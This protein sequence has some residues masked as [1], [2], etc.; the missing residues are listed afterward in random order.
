MRG[1]LREFEVREEVEEFD[2]RLYKFLAIIRLDSH[3]L[4]SYLLSPPLLEA[5]H[6]S[7]LIKNRKFRDNLK[8]VILKLLD[9]EGF[10]RDTEGRYKALLEEISTLLDMLPQQEDSIFSNYIPINRELLLGETLKD[11]YDQIKKILGR[12]DIICGAS[13]IRKNF[14]NYCFF[15]ALVK[16]RNEFSHTAK[17]RPKVREAIKVLDSTYEKIEKQNYLIMPRDL[18]LINIYHVTADNEYSYYIYDLT[19][20]SQP[21]VQRKNIRSRVRLSPNILYVA[22]LTKDFYEILYYINPFVLHYSNKTFFLTGYKKNKSLFFSPIY[23][24]RISFDQNNSIFYFV[25][26]FFERLERIYSYLENQITLEGWEK[27]VKDYWN[28][29][30]DSEISYLQY[31]LPQKDSDKKSIYKLF[32]VLD[33]LS[34]EDL[35]LF[36]NKRLSII[37]ELHRY[38]KY[39]IEK[40]RWRKVINILEISET[41]KNDILNSLKNGDKVKLALLTRE[42]EIED[43]N[44]LCDMIGLTPNIKILK[45]KGVVEFQCDQIPANFILKDAWINDNYEILLTGTRGESIIKCDFLKHR[46]YDIKFHNIFGE[47]RIIGVSRNLSCILIFDKNKD[48]IIFDYKRLDVKW[49]KQL[50]NI[51]SFFDISPDCKSVLFQSLDSISLVQLE[52]NG[53]KFTLPI[54][55]KNLKKATFSADTKGL[56]LATRLKQNGNELSYYSITSRGF[57]KAERASEVYLNTDLEK[58]LGDDTCSVAMTDRDEVIILKK[59]RM[60]E[61]TYQI[62]NILLNNIGDIKDIDFMGNLIVIASK[63]YI[64]IYD[65]DTLNLLHKFEF[66]SDISRLKLSPSGDFLLVIL[67]TISG[68]INKVKIFKLI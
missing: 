39:L 7:G 56:F 24:E 14:K 13:K 15:S 38:V 57:E 62:L 19:T 55:P 34:V 16:L 11:D 63:N 43:K 41:I 42:N 6:S 25:A 3:L 50:G 22:R 35:K 61:D 30:I 27:F 20:D 2:Y 54:R 36:H 33:G 53:R 48:L 17:Y 64:Y 52:E 44:I 21:Y 18:R 23:Q 29:L 28:Y 58:I 46:C 66:E 4:A 31:I 10:K 47:S 40:K 59:V 68:K 65:K 9:F 32:E 67:G 5:Y 26:K 60:F 51:K 49:R 8:R 37:P 12:E 1:I 45:E